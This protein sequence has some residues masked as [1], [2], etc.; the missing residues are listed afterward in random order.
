MIDLD[1]A[2]SEIVE[3]GSRGTAS[4]QEG[5]TVGVG[6]GPLKRRGLP[7]EDTQEKVVVFEVHEGGTVHHDADGMCAPLDICADMP[8]SLSFRHRRTLALA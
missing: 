3:E 1:L 8:S 7:S 5:R 4:G 2:V 6:A